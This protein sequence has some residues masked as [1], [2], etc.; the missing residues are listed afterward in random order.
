MGSGLPGSLPSYL[1]YHLLL[2]ISYLA[3]KIVVV[4]VV[5]DNN[6]MGRCCMKSCRSSSKLHRF[7]ASSNR[8]QLWLRN[9]HRQQPE[10]IPGPNHLLCEVCI[11]HLQHE[12]KI[13]M[14]LLGTGKTVCYSP[15]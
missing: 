11:I 12:F 10:F 13:L 8:R 15:E 14:A 6:R 3:N 5:D 1:L 7:P 4:V 2:Y 9:C